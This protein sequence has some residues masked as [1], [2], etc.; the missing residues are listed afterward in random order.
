VVVAFLYN[1]YGISN[2]NYWEGETKIM[3]YLSIQDEIILC[4]DKKMGIF[5][6]TIAIIVDK[7][8]IQ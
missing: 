8:A 6:L 7:D 4:M 1:I 5:A 3:W 2:N